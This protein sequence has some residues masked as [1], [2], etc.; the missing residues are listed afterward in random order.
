ML[1]MNIMKLSKVLKKDIEK[2]LGII[3]DKR[4]KDFKQFIAENGG[5]NNAIETLKTQLG[6]LPEF[7]VKKQVK[8]EAGQSP[9]E[10]RK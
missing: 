4:R 9:E 2:Y 5:Y 1:S 10:I 3:P 6:Q 8:R 7:Q